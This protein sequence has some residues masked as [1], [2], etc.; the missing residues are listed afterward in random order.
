M[1][2]SRWWVAGFAIA[3]A[4]GCGSKKS[5]AKHEPRSGSGSGSGSVTATGALPVLAPAPALPTPAPGMPPLP[6]DVKVTPEQVALGELLFF[7]PRIAADGKTTC[8]GCHDPD[9]DWA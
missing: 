4:A 7:E 3:V 2:M 5:S 9:H 6:E 8:A 1:M